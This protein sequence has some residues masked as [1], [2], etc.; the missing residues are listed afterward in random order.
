MSAMDG[1]GLEHLFDSWNT[2]SSVEM[3]YVKAPAQNYRLGLRSQVL[4]DYSPIRRSEELN[5]VACI[6]SIILKVNNFGSRDKSNFPL[7]CN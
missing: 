4:T 3:R 5:L 2:G 6:L 7:N 1:C